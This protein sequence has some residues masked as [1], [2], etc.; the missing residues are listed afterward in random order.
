MHPY[1]TLLAAET[2]ARRAAARADPRPPVSAIVA[3]TL[4][5]YGELREMLARLRLLESP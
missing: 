2:R 1:Y 3:D 4:R 5:Q